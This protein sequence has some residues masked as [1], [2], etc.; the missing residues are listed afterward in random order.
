[1][2]ENINKDEQLATLA[3]QGATEQ[4]STTINVR[5]HQFLT[6]EPEELGGTDQGANPLEY[7]LGAL[8]G[9]MNVIIRMVAK[10]LEVTINDLELAADG[11]FDERGLMGE[12][13]IRPY[14]QTINVHVTIHAGTIGDGVKEQLIQ[15]V[16][17]RCPMYTMLKASQ[18][19]FHTNWDWK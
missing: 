2:R 3:V 12:G 7:C 19:S 15:Q 14:F 8:I 5:S 18:I 6:D 1:M 10:E 9:C 11:T 4:F 13:N 16:E 17:L